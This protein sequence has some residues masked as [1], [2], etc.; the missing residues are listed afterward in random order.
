MRVSFYTL[1]CKVNQNETGALAQLFEASGYTVVDTE[2]A[3]DVYVVNSCTVTNFGDQKSR[4]WLRR[5]KREHPGAVT[6]LTGCYPQAFPE[7]AAAIAE[8]DVVTGSGNRRAILAAVQQVLD[9]TAERVVDIR[10]HE[11]GEKFE[12][13]PMDRFAE[14]TRAFVKVEDGCNRRCAYC[15]IPRARG[16]V[17]SRAESSILEELRRLVQTGYREVV[18]TA[19]SL[20]SYGTDT[21]TG[22]AELVEHAAAVPGIDR[23]RLGSLDPDML[24]D[25]DIRRLAAVPQL[26]PQFHL[27]LQSGCDKTLRAMRRPYTTAQYAEVAEKLRKAFGEEELSLTTD[28]I[29]G[30]PGETEEDFEASMA[31]VTAQRFLKVHVFPYSRRSGTPAYDFPDQIPE[32][33]KEARSRRMNE[34]VEAVRAEEASAMQGRKAEVLLE[35][36]LSNTLFTGYTKQYLPVVVTAPGYKSGD[37][38]TVT[39]GEWDGQRAK[40]TAA[41]RNP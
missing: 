23:I 40:A 41:P 31:F 29:V 16:P 18:L 37:I 19:I 13:L 14:H 36:P 7:E 26:C 24:T 20:P 10:P 25:E 39:L 33:E 9:G 2:E 6:V 15:V 1:G 34:A 32:H 17:R 21:G 38:V 27:S 4:K 8:A 35:T 28:V 30:F 3:A 12:E 22:L 11:K 5:Q